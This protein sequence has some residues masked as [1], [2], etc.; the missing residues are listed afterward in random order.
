MGIAIET[1]DLSKV[2]PPDIIAV[3]RISLVIR[4]GEIFSFLGP[5]GAGKTTTV[6]LLTTLLKPTSG[7][8]IV[9]GYNILNESLEL[10]KYMGVLTDRPNLYLRLSA[11]KNL[12]FFAKM[13]GLNHEEAL[14]RINKLAKQFDLIERLGSPVG[15]YSKGMKQKL[16]ILRAMIHSPPIMFLDE[17]TAGLDP[18]AQSS[19]RQTIELAAADLDTTIFM[20]TH[21]LPEAEKLSSKIGVIDKGRLLT[22]GSTSELRSKVSKASKLIITCKN[23]VLE[24]QSLIRD[25]DGVISTHIH[26]NKRSIELE[27]TNMNITTPIIVKKLVDS[28]ASILEVQPVKKSLEDIY[29]HIMDLSD[30]G[31]N[32]YAA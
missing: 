29:K 25:I 18:L 5:N 10:R 8:A 20:T 7:S 26:E 4:E 32:H 31:V 17:P 6:R 1:N 11:K 16:G 24:Y 3:N 2:F 22:I 30:E 23:E 19:V 15:S 21:N 12:L 28:G 14:T 13:Y 27:L 9:H